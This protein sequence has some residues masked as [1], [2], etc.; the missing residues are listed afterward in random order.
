VN[1]EQANTYCEWRGDRL[2]SEAEWEKA[3]RGGLEGMLFSWGDD[4]PVCTVGAKN[5]AQFGS[6][7]PSDTVS[8][9]SFSP[10]GYGLYDMAGNVWE[11]VNDWY[12]ADYYSFSPTSDPPGPFNGTVKVLRGG[13]WFYDWVY[14]RAASR[15]T[16]EPGYRNDSIGFRCA[17][18]IP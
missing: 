4:F 16:G 17:V 15:I 5:G 10:N 12:Q 2:P 1:W 7:M 3:A 18:S 14:S 9:G 8:V 6:C 11:W 13:G